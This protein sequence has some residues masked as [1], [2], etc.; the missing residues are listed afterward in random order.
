MIKIDKNPNEPAKFKA[1]RVQYQA[2]ITAWC[3]DSK[4]KA[5]VLWDNL[6]QTFGHQVDNPISP[7]DIKADLESALYKEQ[8]GLCCYCG[9]KLKAN[10]QSIEHFLPKNKNKHLTFDYTNLMLCCKPHSFTSYVVGEWY[11]Q[12]IIKIEN[13]WEDVAALTSVDVEWI[14]GDKRNKEHIGKTAL[15]KGDKIYVPNPPHCDSSKSK[16]D[17]KAVPDTII[18]PTQDSTDIALFRFDKDGEIKYPARFKL[19][20]DTIKLHKDTIRVLDLNCEKL[21]QARRKA[22]ENAAD[23]LDDLKKIAKK[24]NVDERTLIRT[25]KNSYASLNRSEAFPFVYIDY[26][27]NLLGE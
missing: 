6:G 24:E 15:K 25:W 13:A 18:N 10:E 26:C 1:W 2:D 19:H 7:Q 4:K 16:N 12:I 20:K 27:N 8:H 17:S 11:D 14:K 5:S 23:I 22:W 9:I 3:N 21:K